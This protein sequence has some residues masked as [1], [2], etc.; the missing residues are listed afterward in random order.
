MSDLAQASEDELGCQAML[1][2]DSWLRMY[3]LRR[4]MKRTKALVMTMV[5]VITVQLRRS[6][7]PVS[8]GGEVAIAEVANASTVNISV[9]SVEKDACGLQYCR[10]ERLVGC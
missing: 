6:K 1:V 9:K 3:R 5:K 7:G 8:L 4:T 2:N 10:W